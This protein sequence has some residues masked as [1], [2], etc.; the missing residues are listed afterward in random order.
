MV[1]QTFSVLLLVQHFDIRLNLDL[2][3]LLLPVAV[4]KV[5]FFFFFFSFQ[6]FH[7]VEKSPGCSPLCSFLQQ[8]WCHCEEELTQ[9]AVEEVQKYHQNFHPSEK[10]LLR[11]W[12]A[13]HH[14]SGGQW[15]HFLQG[16]CKGVSQWSFLPQLFF[17]PPAEWQQRNS[18][19][20]MRWLHHHCEQ[21]EPAQREECKWSQQEGDV[22]R[23]QPL[24]CQW[25]VQP[26][27]PRIFK[28]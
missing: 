5:L 25:I 11:Q 19:W 28:C 27:M 20:W 2:E 7:D 17:V 22:A 9:K 15:H 12:N 23:D 26:A 18:N 8:R 10:S 1:F 4:S 14:D 21:L 16:Q 6:R 13:W 24:V 3:N